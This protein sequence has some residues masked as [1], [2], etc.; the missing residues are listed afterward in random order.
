M[1]GFFARDEWRSFS[2]ADESAFF[3]PGVRMMG[4]PNSLSNERAD[5]SES[6]T[7][8]W[9]STSYSSILRLPL[10][11]F[12][13]GC[14]VFSSREGSCGPLSSVGLGLSFRRGLG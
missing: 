3:T 10:S 5:T 11:N 6:L 9:T 13:L 4:T 7:S 8:G 14:D 2:L 12:G 1:I